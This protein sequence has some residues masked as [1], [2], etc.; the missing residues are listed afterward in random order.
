MLLKLKVLIGNSKNLL[1][2]ESFFYLK[3]CFLIILQNFNFA[4]TIYTKKVNCFEE[5][6]FKQGKIQEVLLIES[7]VHVY[8][9]F[10]NSK[11]Q[12]PSSD[13]IHRHI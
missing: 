4:K 3:A 8:R 1:K 2:R 12:K 6:S 7:I 5:R 11:N 10:V 9:Y 13:H